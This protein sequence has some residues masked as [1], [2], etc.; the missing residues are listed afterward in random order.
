L[1]LQY[2]I[3]DLGAQIKALPIELRLLTNFTMTQGLSEK[4][5]VIVAA[6][7]S[8]PTLSH[9]AT[10]SSGISFSYLDLLNGR[11]PGRRV[12]VDG[13]GEGG[14]FAVSL[15]RA[16]HQVI[17]VEQ[18]KRLEP[19]AYD[20]AKKRVFALADYLADEKVETRWQ[21][22]V[23]S[24]ERNEV[25]IE[26]VNG[27]STVEV[28]SVL[29]AGRTPLRLD[30]RESRLPATTIIEIGDCVSSRGIGE[31]MEEGRRIAEMV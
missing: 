30:C 27:V 25:E 1:D 24:V 7:G 5:D 15:A 18:S 19:T 4:P 29:V 2:A 17:L 16:G 26:S 20:Y 6:T 22:R 9:A 3:E 8:I 28:D 13:H 31:A 21:S 11:R 14:E 12:L 10:Q 23:K